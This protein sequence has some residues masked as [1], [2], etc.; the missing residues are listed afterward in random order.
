MRPGGGRPSG[1]LERCHTIQDLRREA[2]RFLPP[3][4]FDYVDGGAEDEVTLRRNSA[5][6]QELELLPR[7]LRDVGEVDVATEILGCPSSL[8]IALAP[9]G[10]TGVVRSGGEVDVAATAG[11]L[12]IPC[13]LSTMATRAVEDVA[14][15]STGPLWF[16]LYV[17]RDHERTRDLIARARAAGC[18]ALLL[19]V[20]TAVTGGRERDLRH[21]I[22]LPPTIRAGT[23]VVGLRRPR[24]SWQFLRGP[25][26]GLGHVDPLPPD[27]EAEAVGPVSRFDPSLTW[28][29]LDWI[30]AAWGGPVVLKGIATAADAREAVAAGAAGIVVSNHGGRQLEGAPATIEALAEVVDAVGGQV[31]VLL[32]SGVR[33]GAD[34]VKALCLGARACLIGR[35][36]LYGYAAGGRAGIERAVGLLA[37]ELRRTMALM[38][39]A[40]LA[41]LDRTAVRWRS[42]GGHRP[43][44][45]D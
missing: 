11:R 41:D 21:G 8:P 22:T 13:T 23:L 40:S 45:L 12:G 42:A 38:G 19:T 16:Q 34:V 3:E 18:R 27:P 20:D 17:F 28:R 43:P 9:T 6:F 30:A 25:V 14:A 1:R 10:A 44:G 37:S 29:D 4:V 24:W 5:A 31:E 26:P 33:R 32:D 7:V 15:A 39:A 35:P 36:F 2:R